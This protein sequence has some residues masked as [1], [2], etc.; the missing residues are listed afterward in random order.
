MG[1]ITKEGDTVVASDS[2]SRLWKDVEL[3]RATQSWN[4]KC[5]DIVRSPESALRVFLSSARLGNQM[6]INELEEVEKLVKRTEMDAPKIG[7]VVKKD[8]DER[9]TKLGK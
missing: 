5:V 7:K 1:F 2:K 9:S 8:R 6:K 4:M 3:K